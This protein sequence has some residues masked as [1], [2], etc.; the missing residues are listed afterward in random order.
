MRI[1][2]GSCLKALA[3]LEAESVRVCVT[4]PP[5]WGL[6]DY[7]TATWEGGD[8]ACGHQGRMVPR[9]D[10]SH[11][12]FLGTRGRQPATNRYGEFFK[13][14][15]GKCAAVRV[16]EQIG[17]EATPEEY[18]SKVVAV[19]RDVRRVLT[20]DGTLWMN[21]GDCY[22]G[23]AAGPHQSKG[24]FK[25][26]DGTGG[27][28]TSWTHRAQAT[29]STLAPGIKPKD[30]V[31]IP[32]MVAFALR[33]D[34]WFLRSEIIWHKPNPMPES[35]EDRPT[36]S[37]EQVFLL[38]KSRRYHYDGAAI[39][40]EATKRAPGNK[41]PRKYSLAGDEKHRTAAGLERI[42]EGSEKR[43]RRDV[44]TIPVQPF[45]GAHFATFPE[46]LVEPCILAGS[47][48][49]DLILD[50]FCGSGTVGVVA[51]RHGRKFVGI[52]LNP[53]YAE[54]ARKR[55]LGPLFAEPDSEAS[56]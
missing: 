6:R 16:D 52:E 8:P 53:E 49:G 50:P 26:G 4:S 43:N 7:G 25:N 33:A 23:R 20:K 48:K 42:R 3:G 10:H 56:A 38:S 1:L 36:K 37:H 22:S 30:L 34:G 51:L 19:F 21:L 31:G 17:L 46:A 41:G 54:M 2:V 45:L 55:I 47:A 11:G 32:W 35:I 28:C 13:T 18:V 29:M 24:D 9:E 12:T 40:E 27:G 15:C 39:A 44:W 14:Q 5:Y